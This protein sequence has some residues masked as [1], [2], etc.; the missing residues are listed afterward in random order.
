MMDFPDAM[1]EV[2]NN[3]K[4]RRNDWADGFYVYVKDEFLCIHKDDGSDHAIYFPKEDLYAEDW[5]IID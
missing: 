3:M 1:R 5:E 4:V 2:L